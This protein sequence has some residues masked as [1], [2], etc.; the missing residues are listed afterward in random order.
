[1]K[2]LT[3]YQCPVCQTNPIDCKCNKRINKSIL[4]LILTMFISLC[5]FAE[6]YLQVKGNIVNEYN[7]YTNAT[8]LVEDS[9]GNIIQTI[10]SEGDFIIKLK[11]GAFY[12]LV[13]LK[14]N[15]V[16][17]EVQV[18]TEVY[19]KNSYYTFLCDVQMEETDY[20]SDY[21]IVAYI[22]YDPVLK[23]FDYAYVKQ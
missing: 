20:E 3:N 22:F 16:T 4:T 6:G 14:D 18:N 17:K 5:V 23:F 13:F 21:W 9:T 15:C 10:N 1:M 12:E 7:K 2:K 19:N 11:L 8:I